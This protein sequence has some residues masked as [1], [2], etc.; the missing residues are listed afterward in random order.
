MDFSSSPPWKKQKRRRKF[1][2]H[3]FVERSSYLPPASRRKNEDA[4]QHKN[5]LSFFFNTLVGRGMSL[6]PPI[7]QS[8]SAGNLFKNSF[9]QEKT[10][11]SFSEESRAKEYIPIAAGKWVYWQMMV[12][13]GCCQRT[14][15][16]V[17][18][19]CQ[20]SLKLLFARS[21]HSLTVMTVSPELAH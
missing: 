2:V 5:S 14:F 15:W 7:K 16:R 8:S 17:S 4:D 20:R 13:M 10:W 12:I 1:I 6:S 3:F 21:T 19:N 18:R 9:R 11:R